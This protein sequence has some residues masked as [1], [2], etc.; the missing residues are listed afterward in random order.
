LAATS[1]PPL[2]LKRRG[3][4]EVVDERSLLSFTMPSREVPI[5]IDGTPYTRETVRRYLNDKWELTE[6]P[7][8]YA[9]PAF[10]RSSYVAA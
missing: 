10:R 5:S 4:S 1:F 9:E 3:F 2:P 6:Q 8:P 7:M